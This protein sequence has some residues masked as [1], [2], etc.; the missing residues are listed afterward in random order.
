MGVSEGTME[1]V[2]RYE[3]NHWSSNVVHRE[4]RGPNQ[5]L[6]GNSDTTDLSRARIARDETLLTWE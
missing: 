4:E 5:A 2:L 6:E 3:I 1:G